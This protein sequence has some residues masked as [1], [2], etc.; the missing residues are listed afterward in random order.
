MSDGQRIV[1]V[2]EMKE[3]LLNI[4]D[5]LTDDCKIF[6]EVGYGVMVLPEGYSDIYNGI[7][8]GTKHIHIDIIVMKENSIM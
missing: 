3:A 1:T 7:L 5:N 2:K 4:V 8:D 6:L